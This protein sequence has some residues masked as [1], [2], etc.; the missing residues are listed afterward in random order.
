[1]SRFF[2]FTT[3]RRGKWV[4]LVLWLAVA[5]VIAPF[6]G[7]LESVEKNESS[8]FL[9]GNAESTKVLAT[10]TKF[11]GGDIATAVVVY[12]RAS[13]LTPADQEKAQSDF[14]AIVNQRLPSVLEPP[15][16]I[17]SPG[18]AEP[19]TTPQQ[20][21][22]QQTQWIPPTPAP[23]HKALIFGIPINAGG[24]SQEASQHLV[25]D[26]DAI[27][28]R[29]EQD[30]NG[31]DVRVTG[32]AGF[33]A[34]AVKIFSDIDSK[35]LYSTLLIVAVLLLI[36]YRSPVLWLIPLITV[37]FAE[38]CSRAVAYALAQAGV[39]VNGETAGVLVVLVFGAGTDY[40]LLIVAR[41]REELRRHEDRHEAMAF[42][43]RRSSPAILAS[44]L[45]VIAGLLCLVAASLNSNRGLGPVSALGI[46]IG[47]I[48]ML[49]L[50][51]AILVITGRWVFWPFVPHFGSPLHEESGLWARIGR[52]VSQRPR[53]VW[54]VVTI[55]LGGMAL[56]LLRLD[57]N[58]TQLEGF[59]GTVD[60][61][62]GQK[63]LALSF[64]Q[65]ATAPTDV[66]VTPAANAA[67]A[68]AAAQDVPGVV[69]VQ[70]PVVQ[71]NTALV[72]VILK[73]DPYSQ[74]AFD[75]V[76]A[77]RAKVKAAAGAGALVGGQSAIQLDVSRSATRDFKLI[78]PMIL[79][80]VLLILGGLLRAVL[81]PVLLILTVILSYLAALGASVLVF[82]F[83][84]GF[85]GM[86]P[87]VPLLI[88][89]F[90]VALGVDYNIFLM[91]RVREESLTLG[92]RQGMLKGLAV[93]GGVITSAGI[94]LAGTFSV[95]GVLPLVVLTEI[96]FTVAFG[97]LLDTLIV[98]S[99]LVPAL[100]LDVGK[101]MWWPSALARTDAGESEG[102]GEEPVA[103][104]FVGEG[105]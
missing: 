91:A 75:A 27:R 38:Q 81:A 20:G 41:Y 88:F 57:T 30:Q 89:V 85:G 72:E 48:A 78:V 103:P 51:P 28:A 47:L 8:S 46:A 50:L 54:I 32:G 44:G 18:S 73:P 24:G 67:K 100:T 6:S 5:V 61:V 33:S 36:T 39:V 49:T 70:P 102:G 94:V 55:V 95:L 98:R 17:C 52:N 10:T 64:P 14:C 84:F 2:A 101:R 65:G 58:L 40:A 45:T 43:M 77:L 31:M 79:L 105:G 25:D 86:D 56:G 83:I 34:D 16:G 19:G 15:S 74:Q 35:L 37:A 93:T 13:G 82:E 66:V 12:R 11:Q 59:R 104:A 90:L 76:D 53:L 21:E 22:A 62:E 9:P 71:G 87:G 99:I 29:V 92:T 7:K 42:A 63:L 26:V 3:G 4:V 60:S 80:V 69:Q 96:G 23:D 1:V 97:V 68:A